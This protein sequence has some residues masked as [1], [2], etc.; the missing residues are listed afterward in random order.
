MII[1]VL[2]ASILTNTFGFLVLLFILWKRL[3][4]DFASEIIFKLG[5]SILLGIGLGKALSIWLLPDYFLWLGFIGGVLGLITTALKFRDHFYELFEGYVIAAL[6]WLSFTFLFDSVKKSSFSSFVAFVVI[7]ILIFVAYF[8]SAHYK[9]FNWYK[10][11]R[12]GFAGLV[13]MI[14]IFV[15]RFILAIIAIDVLSFVG[16]FEV[17]MSG[18]GI[19]ACFILLFDLARIK[20]K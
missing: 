10:S 13:T 5:F 8:L 20:E 17:V 19:A 12:I 14:L 2:I 7:L 18:L 9:S 4:E 6:P 3:K 15:I 1:P 11:G 16:K